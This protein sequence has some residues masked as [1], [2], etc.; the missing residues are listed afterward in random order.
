MLNKYTLKISNSEVEKEY[1]MMHTDRIFLTGVLLS[2]IR[3]VWLMFQSFSVTNEFILAPEYES[4]KWITYAIQIIIVI[5][6]RIYP[7]R[8][9]VIAIPLWIAIINCTLKIDSDVSYPTTIFLFK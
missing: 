9:N 2:V 5:M 7:A 1:I 8:L 3:L 6:Q 4:L